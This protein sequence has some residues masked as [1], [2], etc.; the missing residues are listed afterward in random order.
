M[1]DRRAI[2]IA[3]WACYRERCI[4]HLPFNRVL[5]RDALICAWKEA[6]RQIDV[7]ED[8]RRYRE[9]AETVRAE[10][11]AALANKTP[12]SLSASEQPR[13]RLFRNAVPH[14]GGPN[15]RRL[16]RRSLTA[17]PNA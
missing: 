14:V 16:S 5:F 3:A 10:V 15:P 9:M 12:C 11:A 2:M 8:G 13:P 6:R 4:K 17:R 7:A 1:F